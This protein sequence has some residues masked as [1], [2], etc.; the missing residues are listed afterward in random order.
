MIV[1]E[2]PVLILH[3]RPSPLSS[4]RRRGKPF[5]SAH[6]WMMGYKDT[7]FLCSGPCATTTAA[8][9]SVS[10][11]GASSAFFMR[12]PLPPSPLLAAPGFR[13]KGEKAIVVL[14]GGGKCRNGG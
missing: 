4:R 13:R 3:P 1:L 7:T 8:L 6:P 9:L 11:P 12:L 10:P 14:C 2:I 5:N